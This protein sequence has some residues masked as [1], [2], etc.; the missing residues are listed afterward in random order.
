MPKPA[1][2][3]QL[4]PAVPM[5]SRAANPTI[6]IQAI[7]FII[8]SPKGALADIHLDSVNFGARIAPVTGSGNEK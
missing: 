4:A 2:H 7:P 5:V 3:H 8:R 6:T 1:A